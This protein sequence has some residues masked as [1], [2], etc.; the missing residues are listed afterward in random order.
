MEQHLEIEYKTK[1]DRE[2]HVTVY[3]YFP[4]SEPVF[5]ENVYY[6]TKNQDLYKKAIMCRTRKIKDVTV[7]TVKEPRDYGIMEYETTLHTPLTEDENARSLFEEF[8]FN[9]N[10]LV[11]ITFSNTVRYEYKD[12]Y[13]TWCLDITQFKNHKDYEL[14]YE[15]YH[16]EDQAENHYYQTLKS[17]GIEYEAIEPKFVRALNSLKLED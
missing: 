16:D 2:N 13:G 4:F 8:G 1:I 6:D 7:L 11:E 10:D 9:I 14:E 17:I 15:L 12:A 3:D 5:Q